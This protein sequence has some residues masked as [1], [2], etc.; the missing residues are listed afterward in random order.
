MDSAL[1]SNALRKREFSLRNATILDYIADQVDAY[2]RQP[3]FTYLL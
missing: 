3:H 2:A 1:R